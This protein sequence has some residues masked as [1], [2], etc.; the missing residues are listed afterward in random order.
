ME[1]VFLQEL[2]WKSYF[3]TCF[4]SEVKEKGVGA[5]AEH[6]LHCLNVF[7]PKLLD[8]FETNSEGLEFLAFC[9]VVISMHFDLTECRA[10]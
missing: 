3:A 5:F 8:C 4:S 1:F 6:E 7:M 9:L 2:C 10:M